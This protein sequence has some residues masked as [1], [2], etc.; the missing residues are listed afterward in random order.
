MYLP[1]FSGKRQIL[2]K[3]FPIHFAYILTGQNYG[4]MALASDFEGNENFNL[5]YCHPMEI[6][7][8]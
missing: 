8:L 2:Q 5:A 3:P 1:V 6:V 7:V 4:Q